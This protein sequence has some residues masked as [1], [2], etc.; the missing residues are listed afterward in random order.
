MVDDKEQLT[1]ELKA[2][3]QEISELKLKLASANKEVANH[4]YVTGVLKEEIS[5][6]VALMK[7]HQK[8]AEVY[9]RQF[10]QVK[11]ITV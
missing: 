7:Q 6:K 8:Q 1:D 3:R 5:V 2:A 10:E 4:K 9:K 11:Y